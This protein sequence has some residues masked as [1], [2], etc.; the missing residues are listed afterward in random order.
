MSRQ[1]NGFRHAPPTRAGNGALRKPG[2][3]LLRARR[4][5]PATWSFRRPHPPLRAAPARRLSHVRTD[6]HSSFDQ[7]RTLLC[8]TLTP[9]T[10]LAA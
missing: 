3:L 6:P 1:R 7:V 4:W 10:L 5:D 8:A 9:G 2:R